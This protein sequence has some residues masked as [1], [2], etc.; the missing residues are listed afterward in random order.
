MSARR[1]NGER[2]ISGGGQAGGQRI[3]F[4]MLSG[5]VPIFETTS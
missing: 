5:P 2:L 3:G 1:Y 4:W